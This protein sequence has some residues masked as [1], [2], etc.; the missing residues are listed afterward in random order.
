MFLDPYDHHDLFL[1]LSPDLFEL[2]LDLVLEHEL[3]E[4]LP[5]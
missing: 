2:A 3:L 1:D 4:R 5:I